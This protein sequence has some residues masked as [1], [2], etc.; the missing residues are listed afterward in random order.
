ML[1]VV[2]PIV[3]TAGNLVVDVR[4]VVMV[5]VF[6]VHVDIDIIVAPAA[7]VTP[8]PAPGCSQ[9]KSGPK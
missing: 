4:L 1:W 5:Y 8:A 9:R 6:V 2:L 7:A 3:V